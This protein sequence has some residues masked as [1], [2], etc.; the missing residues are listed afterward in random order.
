[1][2]DSSALVA[3]LADAGPAGTW[4]AEAIA[5]ATLAAPSLAP[6][7]AANILRRQA[8]AGAIDHTQATLAHADLVALPIELWPYAP[9]AD[10]AWELRQ[11][12]TIY[13]AT[14]LALAELVAATVVTLDSRL[15]RAPGPSCPIL[16]YAATGSGTAAPPARST[17]GR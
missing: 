2:I 4:V 7:E 9:L 12:A 1:M 6:F 10:R 17:P 5:G 8:A 11:N 13:D 3:L 14:Y 16:A 15:A